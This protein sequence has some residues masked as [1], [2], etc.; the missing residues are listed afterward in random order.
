MLARLLEDV[1]SKDIVTSL[2]AQTE[3]KAHNEVE[4]DIGS[5]RSWDTRSSGIGQSVE[6]AFFELS[7]SRVF[8]L[9]GRRF[10]SRSAAAKIVN[11]RETPSIK[12]MKRTHSGEYHC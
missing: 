12:M 4:V 10:S 6:V 2:K 7:N 5:T 9:S 8:I 11:H 3:V 1:V